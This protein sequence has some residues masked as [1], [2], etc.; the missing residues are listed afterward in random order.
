MVEINHGLVWIKSS[1][2]GAEQND[3]VEM[4]A[5]HGRVLV[6]CSRDRSGPVLS[7]PVDAWQ[8]LIDFVH[9]YG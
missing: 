4:A 3:C 6:R 2:S 7:H 1:N 8:H 9:N 5:T